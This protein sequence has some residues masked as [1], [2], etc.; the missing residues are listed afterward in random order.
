MEQGRVIADLPPHEMLAGTL[1]LEKGIR[2]PLYLTAMKFAGCDL[3]S[4][5]KPAYIETVRLDRHREK[6]LRW[7]EESSVPRP[8]P[9]GPSVLRAESVSYSYD[10]ERNA[11]ENITFD[12]REGEMVSILGKNGAGKSTLAAIIMGL[13]K[14]DSGTLHLH[15]RPLAGT[16]IAERSSEIGFVMQNPNH[17]ISHHMIREEVGFGPRLRGFEEAE[18]G[19]RVDE[20]LELCGLRRFRNWPINTL[21]YGQKK[22]VT[23]ASILV[24][25]PKLLI[26]DE[27]TAGQDYRHYTDIMEFLRGLNDREGLTII[28]IT[29]DMH[30]ALEY[31]AR[32][33]V[34]TDGKLLRDDTMSRIFSDPDTIEKA[35]LKLTSLYDLAGMAGI[36]RPDLFI[37][38]F[39]EEEQKRR[40]WISQKFASV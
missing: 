9:R 37:D 28:F 1:L 2:E 8:R 33:I 14:P 4:E 34:L 16:T 17:M 19:R 7:F 38:R 13:I 22:R 12:I 31:T 15:D 23:I 3:S 11:V 25:Q 40:T 5:D 39:I 32:S 10:G 6:I 21:S 30:L 36:D 27:P 20:V 24:M 18:T 29:H 26:L 35:N